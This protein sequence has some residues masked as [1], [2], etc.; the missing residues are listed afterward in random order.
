MALVQYLQCIR[1][2]D[3]GAWLFGLEAQN[4]PGR[5]GKIQQILS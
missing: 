1:F 3:N 4:F 5:P 2:Q